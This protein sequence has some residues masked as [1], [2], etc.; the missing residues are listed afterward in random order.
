MRIRCVMLL[1]VLSAVASWNVPYRSG[2]P[3]MSAAVRVAP[4]TAPPLTWSEQPD[5]TWT[6]DGSEFG[7]QEQLTVNYI[8]AGPRDGTPFLLV[9]GFG[10]SGFHWRR[11]VN[12]LASAGFR[13]YHSEEYLT[14]Y[15]LEFSG[16]YLSPSLLGG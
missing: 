1:A 12:V 2:I 16:G 9:H 11:N 15:S 4:P 7:A 3:E 5:N 13:V 6:F 8:A 14:L 10:A